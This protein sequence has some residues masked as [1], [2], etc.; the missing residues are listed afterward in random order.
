MSL[1]FVQT[2]YTYFPVPQAMHELQGLYPEVDQVDAAV[3]GEA[4]SYT[5]E[6]VMPSPLLYII[7]PYCGKVIIKGPIVDTYG[8]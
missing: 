7:C 3:Q 4:T 6:L 8:Y 2:E 5:R 1:V